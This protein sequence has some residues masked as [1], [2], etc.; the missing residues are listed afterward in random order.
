MPTVRIE[1]LEE[2][3]SL[4]K[5]LC[6]EKMYN[7]ILMKLAIDTLSKAMEL[8]PEDTKLMEESIQI[9]QTGEQ[10]ELFIDGRIVPYA[11]YNEFGTYKMP[12]GDEKNPLAVTST[13]GK[14]AYRPFLR[15]AAYRALDDLEKILNE[16]WNNLK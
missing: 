9:R 4:I 16:F 7:E 3:H 1:G 6:D 11:I 13:S 8:A 10:W 2:L 12:V 14:S 5:D 15:P